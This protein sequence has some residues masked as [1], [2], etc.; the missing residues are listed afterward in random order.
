M[1]C[2]VYLSL[3]AV[4]KTLISLKCVEERRKIA[5][6][7]KNKNKHFVKIYCGNER[8]CESPHRKK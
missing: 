4:L 1:K 5:C 8:T 7:A 3:K 6:L 2:V